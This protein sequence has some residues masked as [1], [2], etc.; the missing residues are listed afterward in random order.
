MLRNP[1]LRSFKLLSMA[2]IKKDKSQMVGA[3]STDSSSV[4]FKPN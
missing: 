1:V 3:Q 4:F 2:A